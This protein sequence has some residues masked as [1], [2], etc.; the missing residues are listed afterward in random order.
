[1]YWQCVTR[2]GEALGDGGAGMCGQRAH[3]PGILPEMVNCGKELLLLAAQA[4]DTVRRVGITAVGSVGPSS[5]SD[6]G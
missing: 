5:D 3:L 2:L 1:M 4:A 6:S